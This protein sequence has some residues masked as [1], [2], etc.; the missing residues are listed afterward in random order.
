MLGNMK[1][2]SLDLRERLLD[3]ADRGMPRK[4]AVR[5][6]GVSLATIKR[7]LMRLEQTGSVAPKKKPGMKPRIGITV[8]ERRALWVQL[9]THDAATLEE[10]CELWEEKR[11]VR[12]SVSTMS[13]AIRKLG[14]TLK[15]RV[16]VP[17]SEAKKREV[18]GGSG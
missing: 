8:E 9:E 18:L 6:F 3:A 16:W 2:Y 5:V 4:E 1:T 17:P 12:V 15:K 7:W 11:G 10:H 14:W 13:R